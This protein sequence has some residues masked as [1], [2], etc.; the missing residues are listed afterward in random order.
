MLGPRIPA[1]WSPAKPPLGEQP[2]LGFLVKIIR[3]TNPSV[4][5]ADILLVSKNK[6]TKKQRNKETKKQIILY[7][8]ANFFKSL[9]L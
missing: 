2:G 1:A 6:E 5:T 3:V 7:I 8:Q 4:K 9:F